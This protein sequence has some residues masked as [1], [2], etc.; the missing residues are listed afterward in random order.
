MDAIQKIQE[1]RAHNQETRRHSEAQRKLHKKQMSFLEF[2]VNRETTNNL[3]PNRKKLR[4]A[5]NSLDDI[6]QSLYA[7]IPA[8]AS[9]REMTFAALINEF[10]KMN[11]TM[12]IYLTVIG[13]DPEVSSS[14]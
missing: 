12:H 8:Q 2:L 14:M 5:L 9:D 10:R 7:A 3:K 4:E 6:N 11:D 13:L 1:A